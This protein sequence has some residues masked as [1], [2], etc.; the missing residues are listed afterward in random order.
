MFTFGTKAQ[1]LEALAALNPQRFHVPP[2][3]YFSVAEWRADGPGVLRRIA[4]RF[5][6]SALA[7][8]S[9]AVSEDGAQASQ[10]GAH[11]SLLDIDSSR[12]DAVAGAIAEVIASYR[13]D[14][15]DQVLVQP[16][17]TDVVLSGVIMTRNLGDGSPYYVISYDDESGRTDSITGGTGVSKTVLVHRDCDDAHLDSPRVRQML[18][19]ARDVEALAGEVPLDLEFGIERN[20]RRWVFQVRPISTASRWHPDVERRVQRR[21]PHVERFIRDRSAPRAGVWG[22]RTILGNMP[23]WNP[24][25]MIGATPR[26]L[27]ASLYRE[28][29]TRRTWRLA[30]ERMGYRTMPPE[31]LM[32]MICGR[33]YVDVRNSFNSFL[34]IGLEPAVGGRL[35][36]AWLDRLDAHPELH[37]KVEFEVALTVRDFS[38]AEQYR[39][40]YDGLLAASELEAFEDRLTALT[41][42]C[43]DLSPTGSLAEAER[44]VLRTEAARC[45]AAAAPVEETPLALL[46]R[47]VELIEACTSGGTLPFAVLARHAFIAESLL[48]SAVAR[49]AI[50]AA[51][52]ADF[53]RSIRTV[54]AHLTE[55]MHAVSTG[56]LDRQ[57]FMAR[58][59]HLR[60]GT[61]DIVS[62]PYRDRSDLFVDAVAP[63][64]EIRP[65]RF[66]VS[67]AERDDID[68]LL[69]EA[70]IHA[71]DT[72]GLLE[73]V[74]RAIV[75]REQAKFVFTRDLSE[76]I[77]R[78][79]QWGR[80][81]DLGRD[82]L[83]YLT[84]DMICGTLTAPVLDDVK[85]YFADLVEQQRAR[86]QIEH[87]VKMSYIIR[88]VR[89]V[90]V[91]P[92][93]RAM[94]NFVTTR[95]VEGPVAIVS[96]STAYARLSGK[97]AVIENADPG[98]DWIFSKGVRGLVT[99]FGGA[100]S[101]MAIRCAE[102]DLPAAI[103]CGEYLFESIRHAR[104]VELNCAEKA[105]RA[106]HVD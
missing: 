60:P 68:R 29:L 105:V 37:D 20:G 36:D 9:S 48:R 38:F 30:R 1:T 79:A 33:P 55:D 53:K 34:P 11:R 95:R 72:A 96:S 88:G 52:V 28:I 40:R 31:E 70:G 6:P 104:A 7:I 50:S 56:R 100:N 12:D 25:E 77:E 63:A 54:L 71:V 90:H 13:G 78:L 101:H 86:Q 5:R 65:P 99:K 73:Y 103:G 10:A 92:V 2:V 93:H 18:A 58:Y 59:G 14:P 97:I 94:P 82:D 87:S 47:V 74:R 69:K 85:A 83:S 16:M 44:A 4:E 42:R 17:V 102:L 21:I 35:V 8:R 51:R 22:R 61:Y 24:A 75:G 64:G 67:A 62:L 98:F 57:V 91:I 23:D 27:A 106:V 66:E 19:L 76:A 43:L 81:V 49:G 39:A 45:D 84:L 3:F 32:V 26:P 46:G 80:W 41:N 89:D 15:D